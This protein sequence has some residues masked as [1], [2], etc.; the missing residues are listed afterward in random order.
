MERKVDDWATPSMKEFI[1]WRDGMS[2]EE[3][4]RELQH[5]YTMIGQG[6]RREYRPLWESTN[7]E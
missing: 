2:P 3:Y 6:K 7:K 5:Y 4:E 1:F